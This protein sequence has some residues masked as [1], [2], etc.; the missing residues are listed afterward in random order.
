[1]S[2][3]QLDRLATVFG[4]VIGISTV[5]GTQ[6]VINPKIALTVAGIT[7]V[8]LGYVTNKYPDKNGNNSYGIYKGE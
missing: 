2:K 7:Q 3:K 6:E 4:L 8:F 1:M 5:L